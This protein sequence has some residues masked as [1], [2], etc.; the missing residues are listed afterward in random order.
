MSEHPPSGPTHGHGTS[1]F[2]SAPTG[3]QS[4]PPAWQPTPPKEQSRGLTYV[5]LAIALIATVL[6]VVGWFRPTPPPP[7]QTH[8]STP[9]YTEQQ[10]ADAK[11]RACAAV[12]LVHKG[13][14]LQSGANKTGG[15]NADPAIAEAQAANARLSIISGSW[16]LRDQLDPAT[17][18]PIADMVRHLSDIMLDMGANYLAGA[19][20]ADP[21]QSALLGDGDS[22]FAH[23]LESCK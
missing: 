12:D 5:A 22:T 21:S 20:D 8:P 14:A 13:V 1:G 2:P 11:A 3:F 6:A 7:P 15:V 16:Y 17:P 9:T 19:R 4:G 23:A 18:Q 10:I